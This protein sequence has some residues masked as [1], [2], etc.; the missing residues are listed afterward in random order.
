LETP[1][2]EDGDST[3]AEKIGD[4]KATHE[5]EEIIEKNALTE[6]IN[7]ALEN[8]SIRERRII[9]MRYGL[10][11]NEPTTLEEVGRRFY[12]TRERVRQIEIIALQKIENMNV[13][14]DFRTTMWN[15]KK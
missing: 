11:G 14:N 9:E 2:G 8:L 7:Y 12:I 10:N 15:D 13:L 3:L 6:S 4:E 1:T 5:A